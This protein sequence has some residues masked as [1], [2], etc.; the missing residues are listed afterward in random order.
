MARER[1]GY[2]IKNPGRVHPQPLSAHLR[3]QLSIAA[4]CGRGGGSRLRSGVVHLAPPRSTA[5]RPRTPPPRTPPRSRG[6]GA[7]A[8][9]G[10][11][12]LKT[13]SARQ[14]DHRARAVQRSRASSGRLTPIS[15]LKKRVPGTAQRRHDELPNA[16][17]IAD[18]K[19][20][21]LSIIHLVRVSSL[22][23]ASGL[24]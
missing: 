16:G 14:R 5:R 11:P 12:E 17:I 9:L 19:D 6:A 3:T 4:S 15:A 21:R 23:A 20:R 7:L 13:T 8:A 18:D 2:D 1:I 10:P 24:L 22:H